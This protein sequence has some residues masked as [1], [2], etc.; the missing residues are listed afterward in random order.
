MAQLEFAI[1]IRDGISWLSLGPNTLQGRSAQV[2]RPSTLFANKT[3]ASA[4]DLRSVTMFSNCFTTCKQRSERESY[5]WLAESRKWAKSQVIESE[6][7]LV[8]V[9]QWFIYIT[10]I[11]WTI[12]N[13]ISRTVVYKMFN[14]T[15][16]TSFNYIFCTWNGDVSI[17]WNAK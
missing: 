12:K 16:S 17:G 6:T 10:Y 14:F 11:T 13:Y 15:F 4:W 3:S 7:Y 8:R 1:L 9:W 2:K 5:K